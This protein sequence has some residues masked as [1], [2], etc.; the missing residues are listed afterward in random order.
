[1]KYFLILIIFTTIFFTKSENSFAN[2][3]TNNRILERKD[4]ERNIINNKNNFKS[5][6]YK[7]KIISLLPNPKGS[8]KNNTKIK[9]KNFGSEKFNLKNFSI[10]TNTEKYI[11]KENEII[12]ANSSKEF[13]QINKKIIHL[14]NKKE[15]IIF[16]NP[17]QNPIQKISYKNSPEGAYFIYDFSTALFYFNYTNK[18]KTINRSRIIPKKLLRKKEK[19]TKLI[20]SNDLIK[21]KIINPQKR[22]YTNSEPLDYNLPKKNIY[23]ISNFIVGIFFLISLLVLIIKKPLRK[24]L[25]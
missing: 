5:K 14:N 9:I 22:F 4:F 6:D 19:K 18:R 2:N 7:I 21:N 11:F 20:Y 12:N 13:R 10:I 25:I 15:K 17:K 24:N 16:L 23:N 8:D 1:M 3:L